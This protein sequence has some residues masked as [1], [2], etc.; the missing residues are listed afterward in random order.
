M[1]KLLLLLLAGFV[2]FS[3]S[4]EAGEVFSDSL[5]GNKLTEEE[6]IVVANH[7]MGQTIT[8]TEALSEAEALIAFLDQNSSTTRSTSRSIRNIVV[9]TGNKVQTRSG[10]SSDSD[11]LAYIVNFANDMGYALISADRRTETIL[12]M[13]SDGNIDLESDETNPGLDI[14]F[15]NAEDMYEQQ[16]LS[17]EDAETKLLEEALAKMNDGNVATRAIGYTTRVGSWENYSTFAPLVKVNWGQGPPFNNNAPLIKNSVTNKY[18]N[19]AAGCVATAVAQIM[20]YHQYPASYNWTEINKFIYY[21]YTASTTVKNE[22][23]TMFRTIGNNVSMN[24]G[25]AK[26]GGSGAQ[27]VNARTHFSRMGYKNVGAMDAYNHDKIINSIT[28]GTP[29][30]IRG[31]A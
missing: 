17:A 27:T 21:Y 23:A 12:A 3:C 22:I 9:A 14:F 25:L 7:L 26:D 18:E 30:I 15:A 8:P 11:T 24:W 5:N 10:E 19:A 1:K 31:N 2:A 4:K 13:S 28:S 29:L 16:I 6:A 20:S